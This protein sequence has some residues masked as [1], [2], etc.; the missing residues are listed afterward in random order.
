M[1]QNTIISD[2]AISALIMNE[3][4]FGWDTSFPATWPVN[5]WFLRT[6]E[7]TLYQNTGTE[8]S[9]IFTARIATSDVGLIF[10]LG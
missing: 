8:G 7:D 4:S 2:E 6:D 5:G 9:P 10:A 1:V 3:R